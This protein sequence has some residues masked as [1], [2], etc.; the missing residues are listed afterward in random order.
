MPP[1]WIVEA[2]DVVEYVGL[3]LVASAIG[4]ARCPFGL[5]RREEALH[6]RIVPHVARPAHAADYA[7][8]GQEALKLGSRTSMKSVAGVKALGLD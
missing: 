3:G 7:V 5:Q 1:L 4:L 2:F 8:V 6:C